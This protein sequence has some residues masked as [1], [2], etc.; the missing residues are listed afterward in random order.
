[1]KRPSPPSRCDELLSIHGADPARWPVDARPLLA[2]CDPEQRAAE[3]QLD[4]WLAS[5]VVPPA[6]A[7]LRAAIL[8][9]AAA[10]APQPSSAGLRDALLWLWHELGGARLAA[11]AFA[12]AI[13]A[14]LALGGGLSPLLGEPDPGIED[15]LSLAQIDERYLALNP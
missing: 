12:F 8:A 4:N 10:A 1:M 6:P 13:V 15:L 14:G 2:E 9:H 7:A 11:P 3:A 5:S